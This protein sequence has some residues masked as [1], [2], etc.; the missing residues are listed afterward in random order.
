MAQNG[1][2]LKCP[3][4]SWVDKQILVYSHNVT[5]FSNKKEWTFVIHNIMNH[6]LKWKKPDKM[7]IYYMILFIKKILEMQIHL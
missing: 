3:F 4:H 7:T 6:Y 5:L 2:Q 1:K